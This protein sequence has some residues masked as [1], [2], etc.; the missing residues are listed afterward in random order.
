LMK[1]L[2]FSHSREPGGA[3]L[4]M[5]E[6][7]ERID[8][9]RF[10]PVLLAPGRGEAAERAG[11]LGIRIL[12]LPFPPGV[13]GWRR[14]S[15]LSPGGL[16][17]AIPMVAKLAG[18]LRSEKTDVIY[19]HS[20]KAHVLGGLAGRLAGT[21]V[22]WHAR[23]IL[24][25][26]GLRTAMSA[27]SHLVPDRIICVSKA[28]AGQFPHVPGK[29]SVVPNGLDMAEV[30]RLAMEVPRRQVRNELGVP[31]SAP[32]VGMVSRLAPGKGQHLFIEAAAGI[33]EKVPGAF[34]LIAGGPLFGEEG[35][36]EELRSETER[37]GLSKKI[38]FAG[39]LSNALPAMAALDVLVHC[40]VV[41]EGFGRSLA[42]AMALGVPVAATRIGAI[43][44][45]VDDGE[46]GLLAAPGDAGGLARAVVR[47]LEDARLR[48]KLASGAK[49][50]VETGLRMDTAMATI[51]KIL[52]SA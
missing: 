44:E 25:R 31:P 3:E 2:F 46:T 52:E 7:M 15:G 37:R 11:R 38:V 49:R 19:T 13:L 45:L 21:R 22:I 30:R 48:S 1:V 40:P 16:L 43:P 12:G 33:A 50:K 34:F 29:L 14:D 35:Y 20:Q 26:P 18:M 36:L 8:R 17:S 47:L 9:G 6:L 24:V 10:D 41:P 23:E 42:E 4:S 5:L 39:H 51:E 32:L 28:V 27:M